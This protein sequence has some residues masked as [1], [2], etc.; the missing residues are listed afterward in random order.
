VNNRS[1]IVNPQAYST[2]AAPEPQPGRANTFNDGGLAI[3]ALMRLPSG[4]FV[5]PPAN[6]YIADTG[7]NIIRKVT[8][9]GIINTI[10][11]DSYGAFLGD[12]LPAI[13]AELHAPT[14][15]W[16]RFLRQHLY[17]RFR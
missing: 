2:F 17:C 6:V 12:T 9:N 13:N 14:D 4:V 8:P 7:D 16:V 15:V 1:G 3:N 11:G 10:V 5:I